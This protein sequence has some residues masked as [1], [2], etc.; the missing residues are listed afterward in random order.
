MKNCGFS[1]EL[2]KQ[3]EERYHKLYAESDKWVHDKIKQA[4]IDGYVTGAFGLRVRTPMLYRANPYKLTNI[5][6]AESR[7]AGNALGQGWG[8]LNNRAMNA[9]LKRIDEAGLTEDIYPIAAI[10]DACYYMVRNNP[11]TVLWLNQ[12]TTEEAK[13]QDDPVISHPQVGLEGQLD[14]FFPDWATPLTLPESLTEPELIDLVQ[15][16]ME[17]LNE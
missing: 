8:L 14:L 15:K 13:W 4:C 12:V 5:Q 2:A 17:K 7:T 1:E 16:H 10:H 9:V 11:E 3:I 6:A